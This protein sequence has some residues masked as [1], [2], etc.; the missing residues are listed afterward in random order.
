VND[1]VTWFVV[2]SRGTAQVLVES[3]GKEPMRLLRMEMRE[4]DS[5]TTHVAELLEHGARESMYDRLVLI[6]ELELLG[7]M[8]GKLGALARSRL[9]ITS[10]QTIRDDTTLRRRLRD[11]NLAS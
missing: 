1:K 4:P 8:R 3:H 6:A 2:G 11:V 9:V 5:A 7:L 10:P